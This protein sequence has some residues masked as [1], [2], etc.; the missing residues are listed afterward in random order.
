MPV[1][2]L[3]L[4]ALCLS[5]LLL[6]AVPSW[7]LGL[8]PKAVKSTGGEVSSI[9]RDIASAGVLRAQA[10]RL[11][12]LYLQAGLGLN[13][14]TANRQIELAVAQVD[15]ELKQLSRYSERAATLRPLARTAGSWQTL[16][17]AVLQPYSPAA[18]ERMGL[19]A[20][21]LAIHA[22]KLAMEIESSAETSVGRL[23]DLSSRQSMLA[24]RLARLYMLGLSG[25]RSQGLP[26]DLAQTRLEF[27]AGLSELEAAPES[28]LAAREALGLI[29]NQWIFFDNAV[30]QAP[31]KGGD[32]K[33]AENVATCSERI[34]ESLA[35]MTAQYA[36]DFSDSGRTTR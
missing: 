26:V 24:Q 10:Q 1:C 29:R 9:A 33:A 36:Q 27:M 13:A 22:G 31:V 23:L 32:S 18:A 8:A 2:R 15:T 25:N 11:A 19:L 20:E 7:A 4:R 21:E 12:K 14:S 35:L 17:A 28:S 3:S 16:R 5:V 6:V 34:A 30:R